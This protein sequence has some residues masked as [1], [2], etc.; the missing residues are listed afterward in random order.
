MG[1]KIPIPCRFSSFSQSKKLHFQTSTI[2]HLSLAIHG[3]YPASPSTA[4]F[5]AY[6]CTPRKHLKARFWTELQSKTASK[7][8]TPAAYNSWTRSVFRRLERHDINSNSS[9]LGRTYFHPNQTRMIWLI[10]FDQ[11]WLKGL[12][13]DERESVS[14]LNPSLTQLS[15][16]GYPTPPDAADRFAHRHLDCEHADNQA[17]MWLGLA[18]RWT[19]KHSLVM[20]YSWRPRHGAD[21]DITARSP[22]WA[23]DSSLA[24]SAPI[25]GFSTPEQTVNGDKISIHQRVG[26]LLIRRSLHPMLTK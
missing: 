15:C 26:D 4:T 14:G 23:P 12:Y 5:A 18:G 8:Q 1:Y 3:S 2:S 20:N 24:P 21:D 11:N 13:W 9:H 25:S 17:V 16:Q 19:L 10:W 6:L 7:P 22:V